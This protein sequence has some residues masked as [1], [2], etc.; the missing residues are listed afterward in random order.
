M[1]PRVAHVLSRRQAKDF[2]PTRT[3][4]DRHVA[5]FASDHRS[6]AVGFARALS[7]RAE[8]KQATA[9]T[10]PEALEQV[11]NHQSLQVH[12]LASM[13]MD[14]SR[15]PAANRS[16]AIISSFQNF[17]SIRRGSRHKR[18]GGIFDLL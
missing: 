8:R 1:K 6:S 13:L 16:I 15:R 10:M 11:G 9:T 5:R 4:R 14:E 3:R 7:R 18:N 17:S 12:I 2:A